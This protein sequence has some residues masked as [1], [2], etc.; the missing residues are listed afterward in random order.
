[1]QLKT[2]TDREA[3]DCGGCRG[4]GVVSD[5][6]GGDFNGPKDCEDCNGLGWLF[7]YSDGTLRDVRGH[8]RGKSEAVP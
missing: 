2:K 5:F 6:A 3:V 8:I 7:R 4:H 1:M